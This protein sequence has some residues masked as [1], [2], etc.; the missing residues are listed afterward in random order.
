MSEQENDLL[1]ASQAPCRQ[2]KPETTTITA[3]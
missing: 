1:Q 3:F 2:E